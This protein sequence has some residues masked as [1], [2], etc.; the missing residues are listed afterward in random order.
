MKTTVA[1]V[2]IF[3]LC[4]SAMSWAGNEPF[5]ATEEYPPSSYALSTPAQAGH[6][7]FPP[8]PASI[9]GPACAILLLF[10]G[11]RQDLI[12]KFV[13]EGL[14]P[15]VKQLFFEQG[16]VVENCISIWPSSSIPAHTAITTAAFPDRNGIVSQRWLDPARRYYRNYIGP[17]ILDLNRDIET[18]V[19]TVFERVRKENMGAVSVLELA[20]R[21]TGLFLPGPATDAF[22]MANLHRLIS[23]GIAGGRIPLVGKGSRD[24]GTGL[25]FVPRFIMV[26]CPE[27]DHVHH[28]HPTDSEEIRN[29]YSHLDTHVGKLATFLRHKN[30]LDRCFIGIVSDHG[31]SD[32]RHST[33]LQDVLK[34]EGLSVY[35]PASRILYE[36]GNT[37]GLFS[38]I[39]V[40]SYHAF[41]CWGG[42]SDGLIYLKGLDRS[43]NTL[44]WDGVIDGNL[45]RNYPL[46]GRKPLNLLRRLVAEPGVGLVAYREG[47][48]HFVFVNRRGQSRLSGSTG[49]GWKYAV[50]SGQDPFQYD[51]A[52]VLPQVSGHLTEEEW[53]DATCETMCPNAPVNLAHALSHPSRSPALVLVANDG[54]DFIPSFLKTSIPGSHGGIGRHHVVVPFM[55]RGPGVS[56]QSVKTC[57]IVDVVPTMLGLLGI[58]MKGGAWDGR[59]I[60]APR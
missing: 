3:C 12:Q 58:P 21:G 10:D 17:G 31:M 25:G 22:S 47:S 37:D 11:A 57:R 4:G 5:N 49:E 1:L 54:Y 32:V 34:G 7:Q 55:V 2:L 9:K 44:E 43:T 56:R 39:R 14:M 33:S 30:L 26:N 18:R 20:N 59:N 29:L 24:A 46:P 53:L 41:V 23:S 45:L 15:N 36:Q 35:L 16:V 8:P 13:D 19:M 40:D 28:R 48:R 38:T 42:N 52:G 50:E 51:E 60:L 27:V 6:P